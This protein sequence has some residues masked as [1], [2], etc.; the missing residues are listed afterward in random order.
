MRAQSLRY[1][2]FL[3]ALWCSVYPYLGL[4]GLLAELTLLSLCKHLSSSLVILLVLQS[5]LPWWLRG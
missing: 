4:L 3:Q 2:D 5:R 1:L